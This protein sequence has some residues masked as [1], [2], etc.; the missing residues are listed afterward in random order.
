MKTIV[1]SN[2]KGGCGKSTIAMNLSTFF[3]REGKRTLLI[4]MDSQSQLTQWLDAG[5]GFDVEMTLYPALQGSVPIESVIQQTQY[6][7]LRFIASTLELE[8]LGREMT[9]RVGYESTLAM[10]LPQLASDFD[11]IVIDSPNQLSPIQANAIVPADLIVV[12]IDGTKAVRSYA[13]LFKLLYRLRPDHDNLVMH[14]LSDVSRQPIVRERTI[15]MLKLFGLH[16]ADTEIRTCPFLATVDENGANIFEYAPQSNGAKDIAA[17]GR[18]VFARLDPP[19]MLLLN[20]PKGN[21]TLISSNS[22]HHEQTN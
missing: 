12:P 13:H 20:A 7:N 5:N 10:M 6:A 1:V 22:P 16:N 17:L 15:A 11:Y 9:D 21:N 2:A 14:V 18:E 3:A 19:E 8:S 4:D